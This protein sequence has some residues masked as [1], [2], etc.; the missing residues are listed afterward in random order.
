MLCECLGELVEYRIAQS[1]G[2]L[3]CCNSSPC[4]YRAGDYILML[5][6]PLVPGEKCEA[7]MNPAMFAMACKEIA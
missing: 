4:A 7:S 1:D 3:R 2:V 5:D 6:N